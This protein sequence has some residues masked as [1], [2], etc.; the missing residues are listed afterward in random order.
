MII[1]CSERSH[2]VVCRICSD[3]LY[4]F[5]SFGHFC[6]HFLISLV[7][8]LLIL[9][10]FSK[11][12]LLVS[13]FSSFLFSF[14]FFLVHK[15][16]GILVPWPGVESVASAVEAW[17]PNHWTARQFPI[18]CFII[19]CSYYEFP[20]LTLGWVFSFFCSFLL[21]WKLWSLIWPSLL[22]MRSE[23]EVFF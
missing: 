7:R 18:F 9:W 11:E 21:S 2:L 1:N 15:A 3:S 22:F 4:F 20:S 8:V 14:F 17:C 5:Y 12:Q 10:I 6:L 16:C 13:V 19:F 23:L